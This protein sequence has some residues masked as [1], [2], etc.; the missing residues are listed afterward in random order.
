M[1]V[2]TIM[3]VIFGTFLSVLSLL[4]GLRLRKEEERKRREH[5]EQAHS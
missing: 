5:E 1:W 2:G 3:M 4:L